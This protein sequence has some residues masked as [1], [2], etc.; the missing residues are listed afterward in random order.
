MGIAQNRSKE[1]DAGRSPLYIL[2]GFMVFGG[3]MDSPPRWH[4]VNA[5][6]ATVKVARPEAQKTLRFWGL[7]GWRNV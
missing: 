6:S 7:R 3:G 4:K 1:Y 5:L 2:C